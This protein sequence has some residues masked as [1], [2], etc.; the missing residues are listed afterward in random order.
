MGP[1]E[2]AGR[3][4]RAADHP[5]SEFTTQV[6]N[7]NVKE[8]YATGDT[9]QGELI[10]EAQLP[11]DGNDATTEGTY[12]KFTTERPTFAQDDL[13]AKLQQHGAVV[14]ATPAVDQRGPVANL[15]SSLVLWGEQST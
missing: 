7:G 12:T 11:D 1:A 3:A 8:I 4:E 5:L 13:L 6:L 14:R 15:I 10:T 9:I 2:L